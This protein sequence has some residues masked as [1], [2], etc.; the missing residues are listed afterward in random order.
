VGLKVET[1]TAKIK[2]ARGKTKPRSQGDAFYCF[3]YKKVYAERN[4][5]KPRAAFGFT[6]AAGKLAEPYRF[7]AAL[8][9]PRAATKGSS[10]WFS[11][12][13]LAE[14]YRFPAA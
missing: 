3:F 7:P 14:P 10:P 5:I 2:L 11:P 8:G 12:A 9:K 6:K 4:E 1:E 13:P